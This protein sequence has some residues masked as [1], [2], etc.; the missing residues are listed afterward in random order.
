MRAVQAGAPRSHYNRFVVV[1]VV[2]FVNVFVI[3]VWPGFALR[4]NAHRA[5]GVAAV[6]TNRLRNRRK[7]SRLAMSFRT[8]DSAWPK[9]QTSAHANE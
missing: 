4:H 2:V 6:H 8:T 5:T 3:V 7:A 9:R 1:F